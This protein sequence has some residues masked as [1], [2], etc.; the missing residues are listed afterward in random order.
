MF[1]N[2]N[3]VNNNI[4]PQNLFSMQMKLMNIE[5][6]FNSFLNQIQN[7]PKFP[8]QDMIISDLSFQFIDFGIEL[9]NLTTINNNIIFDNN[10]KDKINNTISKLNQISFNIS[11]N[12]MNQQLNIM[13]NPF[14]NN[15]FN[16][17]KYNVIIEEEKG[18]KIPLVCD[19]NNTVDE[20]IKK[21]LTKIGRNDLFDRDEKEFT[22]W[23]YKGDFRTRINT[24]E[25]KSKTLSEIASISDIIVFRCYTLKN[26]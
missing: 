22:F 11:N 10:I 3:M 1:Q 23:G 19:D 26:L 24:Q 7:I 6:Q 18:T 2:Y 4:Q 12:N 8:I 14:N 21:Y 16:K 13:N 17:H 9:L 25:I 15:S 20:V 5:S